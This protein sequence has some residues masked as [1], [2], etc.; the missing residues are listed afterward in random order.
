MFNRRKSI[1]DIKF[2]YLLHIMMSFSYS[3]FKKTDKT[4]QFWIIIIGTRE[5]NKFIRL[6]FKY[7]LT[8][9]KN[10]KKRQ[11]LKGSFYSDM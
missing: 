5:K 3:V 4:N 7:I 1:S 8:E 6:I 2:E 9:K 11:T 10:K